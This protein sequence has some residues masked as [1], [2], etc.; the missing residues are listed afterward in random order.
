MSRGESMRGWQLKEDDDT[1]GQ[2]SKD[3]LQQKKRKSSKD[4]G[5]GTTS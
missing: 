1:A 2:V 3:K 4:T 5:K